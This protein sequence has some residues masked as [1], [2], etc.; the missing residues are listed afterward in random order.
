MPGARVDIYG[1]RDP[2]ELPAYPLSEAARYLGVPLSTLRAWTVGQRGFK[3]I[4][5]LPIETD[6]QLSFYNFIEAFVVNALRR[7]H[8]VPLQRLRRC[9]Q[10][11][12]SLVPHSRHPLADL[13][14]Q[15]FA[16]DVFFDSKGDLVN[17]TREG[18]LGLREILGGFLERVEKDPSGPVRL[19]PLTRTEPSLS[20]RMIVIDPRISFGRPVIA[21]TGIP[22]AVIHERWKAGD[23]VAALAD[24]YNRTPDEIEEA[25]RY[26]AA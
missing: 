3:P 16:R 18:Q 10:S 26:E 25:L 1:S 5:T 11:L 9:V 13:D 17:V 20:P 22:T 2:R 7:R 8:R 12:R 19:Y 14:L 21:G 4:I 15:T 6:G 24:D 23:S